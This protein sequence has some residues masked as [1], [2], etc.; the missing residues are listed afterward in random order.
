MCIQEDTPRTVQ[1]VRM[2]HTYVLRSLP[3]RQLRTS[4]NVA[5]LVAASG[6][7]RRRLNY[8]DKHI[9]IVKRNTATH[10]RMSCSSGRA[11]YVLHIWSMRLSFAVTKLHNNWDRIL[12]ATNANMSNIIDVS[13]IQVKRRAVL[14]FWV[15]VDGVRRVVACQLPHCRFVLTTIEFRPFSRQSHGWIE[16]PRLTRLFVGCTERRPRDS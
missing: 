11:R 15:L 7:P 5:V 6:T 2:R 4:T 3:W 1:F 12:V 14:T 8:E 13:Q 10:I 16:E 9:V